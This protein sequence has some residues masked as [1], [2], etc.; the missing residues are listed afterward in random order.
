MARARGPGLIRPQCVTAPSI[1]AAQLS[2]KSSRGILSMR[3]LG[4]ILA[5]PAPSRT[6]RTAALSCHRQNLARFAPSLALRVPRRSFRQMR[7]PRWRPRTHRPLCR[8][9][10]PAERRAKT[11]HS[12]A[13]LRRFLQVRL[14]W[15]SGSVWIE[16]HA[17]ATTHRSVDRGLLLVR[18]RRPAGLCSWPRCARLR[19]VS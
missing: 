9:M 2:T 6:A 13:V 17:Y 19:L 11:M 14:P 4:S 5:R 16:T 10:L 15:T 7:S 8:A 3:I 1:G 18:L 12:P